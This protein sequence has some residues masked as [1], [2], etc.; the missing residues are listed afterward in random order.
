[1]HKKQN[2]KKETKMKNI[3]KPDAVDNKEVVQPETNDKKA[4][5]EA[6]ISGKYKDLFSEKVK[7]IISKRLKGTEDA[8][9][10]LAKYEEVIEIVADKFGADKNDIDLIKEKVNNGNEFA[11]EDNKADENKNSDYENL[12]KEIDAFKQMME[13]EKQNKEIKQQLDN[14]Y[15]QSEEIAKEYPDFDL[16]GE[17]E[18]EKF[19]ELLRKGVD[20]KT[21][22]QVA[23]LDDILSAK[24]DTSKDEERLLSQKRRPVE[25]GLSAQSPAI[26]KTDVSKLTPEQRALIA[27][28]V[29]MGEKITF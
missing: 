13:Q 14:W 26:I 1:M 22:Y 29:A 15:N 2:F 5:F 24:T 27:K 21:A 9:S 11:K 16:E 4:E 17:I 8:K 28:R 23:H 10:K 3:I 20:M 12:K 25:N 18:N 19:T 6:L 7:E